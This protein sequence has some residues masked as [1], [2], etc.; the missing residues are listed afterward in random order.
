M[1]R[2][3]IVPYGCILHLTT[4][5]EEWLKKYKKLSGREHSTEGTDGLTYDHGD[6]NYYVGVFEENLGTLAHELAHVCLDVT[7]RVG[8]GD[9]TMEQEQF[10]YM[11][12]YLTEQSLKVLPELRGTHHVRPIS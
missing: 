10:C 4:N 9:I 2:I 3:K 6:G 12:G 5:R 7:N 11:L 8:L 1:K